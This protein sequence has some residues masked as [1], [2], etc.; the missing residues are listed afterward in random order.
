MIYYGVIFM[1]GF[2]CRVLLMG[3]PVAKAEVLSPAI[4]RAAILGEPFT[5]I[6]A[7]NGSPH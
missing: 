4:P 6:H 3:L 5:D 1:S 7:S 2:N